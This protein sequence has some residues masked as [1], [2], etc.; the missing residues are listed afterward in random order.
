M[1]FS[2]FVGNE[3][4]KS[5]LS[6]LLESGRLPHAIILEGEEGIGKRTF[7]RELVANL[8]CR[9]SKNN[10]CYECNQCSKVMR[11]IHP[12][13]FEYTA[14]NKN[15]AFSIDII[16]DDVRRD[17]FMKPNEADYKVYILG[18][19]QA[20]TVEAQNAILKILEEPPAYAVFILTVTNKTALLETVLSRSVVYTINGVTPKQGADYICSISD[21]INFNDAQNAISVCGGNIGKALS[22][23]NDGKLSE[24]VNICNNICDALINDSEYD[25]LVSIAPFEKNNAL[26][27]EAVIMLK[28]VFRDAMLYGIDVQLLSGQANTAKKLSM[29]LTKYKLIKMINVCDDIVNLANSNAN[30]A[31]L[32]TKFCYDLRKAQNR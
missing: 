26:L 7:A 20:M 3:K 5:E 25:L 15:K 18:N 21:D 13:V 19:C 11:G 31:I 30:N 16:R 24:L 10:A 27:V 6:Y 14:P 4:V 1:N 12:D 9:E 17:V 2:T 8:F 32:I 28:S 23:L 29:N 22:T